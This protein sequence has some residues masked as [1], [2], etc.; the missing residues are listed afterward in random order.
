MIPLIPT[1][2]LALVS[3]A[4]SAFVILRTLLSVLSPRTLSRRLYP[5]HYSPPC[6]RALPPADKSYIW[7]ALCDLF[8]L[9]VFVW[10][11][12]TQWSGSSSST[13][14]STPTISTISRLWLALTLR[15]TCFLIV[16]ALILIH[17]RLRKS[18]SFGTAHC[19]LWAPLVILA[20]AST[21]AAGVF[22]TTASPGRIFRVG[23][24]TYSCAIALV[25]TIMFGCLVGTLIIIRRSIENFHR[26]QEFQ[27]SNEGADKS[28]APHVDVI[29]EGGSWITSTTSSRQRQ[30]VASLSPYSTRT[31]NTSRSVSASATPERSN[32]PLRFPFWPPPGP[33]PYS[34]LPQ[35]PSRR[36]DDALYKDFEPFR[37]RAQS[38]RTAA[39]TLTSGNSWIT[40][41]LGTHP[42]LTAWSYP[43]TLS[44]N[45]GAR[46]AIG[47]STPTRDQ[48]PT[49]V[50]APITTVPSQEEKSQP[51]PCP[52]ASPVIE[53]SVL[54]I[55]AWLAGVW[56]PLIFALPYVILL[57]GSS[58]QSS[59]SA[60][61]LL[62]ISVT[63]SSPILALNLLLRHPIPLTSGF[64]NAPKDPHPVARPSYA[65]TSLSDRHT[66]SSGTD[67]NLKRLFGVLGPAP[68][69][70]LLLSNDMKTPQPSARNGHTEENRA[71]AGDRVPPP[72][73]AQALP[74]PQHRHSFHHQP[75][76]SQSYQRAYDSARGR[77]T[78]PGHTKSFSVPFPTRD[79]PHDLY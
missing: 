55:L 42:T 26:A 7:L 14:D 18:V 19:L 13:H 52:S 46:P 68:K 77:E 17:V 41:S 28:P 16:S 43:T 53:I 67:Y 9:G 25:N 61:I 47:A 64:L 44:S 54:R 40:S 6:S 2:A 71:G 51:Q 34:S 56:V 72:P 66:G 63:I 59:E 78:R 75:N 36:R 62:A 37:R 39:L 65:S 57:G 15:Q 20:T 49:R 70:S 22:A 45:Q 74:L 1:L 33:H 79:S 11:A 10:E 31:R 5:L 76:Y 69:L 12:F 21:I 3:L 38:L 48:S 27:S 24:I 73:R 8:A 35:T 50:R 60:S 4:C 58:L 23:F 32:T 30:D 29:R